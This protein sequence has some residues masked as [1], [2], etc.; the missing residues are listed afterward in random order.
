MFTYELARR[1]RGAAIT[2]NALHPGSVGTNFGRNN[3]GLWNAIF[4]L[5]SY[6]TLSPEDGAKTNI[7]LASSPDVTTV[8]GKYFDNC[9][10]VPS[11]KASYDEG[12]QKRLWD[13]S[14]EM[15]RL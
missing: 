7:Y 2:V 12:A 4:N 5:V 11:S 15:V 14:A 3:G 10:A 6:F 8:S 9:K 13:V 1:V